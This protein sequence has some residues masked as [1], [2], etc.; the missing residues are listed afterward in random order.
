[1]TKHALFGSCLAM[2]VPLLLVAQTPP[3]SRA[4]FVSIKEHGTVTGKSDAEFKAIK[5]VA[6]FGTR[7]VMMI[8]RDPGA[9]VPEVHRQMSHILFVESGE[10]TL[11]LGGELVGRQKDPS[12]AGDRE[13]GTAIRNGVEY[14]VLP[15]DVFQVPPET[16]HQYVV[17]P[18]KQMTILTI[19]E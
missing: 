6:T 4:V 1:M 10:G 13:N 8:R 18:G 14:H 2:V 17:Q 7:A 19:N 5:Q 11:V 16:P 3:V 15:G 9:S 12:G